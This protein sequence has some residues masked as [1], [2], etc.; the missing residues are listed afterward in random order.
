M[1]NPPIWFLK[2]GGSLITDKQQPGVIRRDTLQRLAQEIAGAVSERQPRTLLL[3]HGSG[4]FGHVVAK[5]HRLDRVSLGT[6]AGRMTEEQLTGVSATQSRAAQLHRL[7]VE[8]LQEAGLRPFSVVP[9]SS[10]TASA[11]LEKRSF[12]RPVLQALA[13]GL[14]PVTHGDVVMDD[15]WGASICSTE[16][17]FRALVQEFGRHDV[18]V[19]RVL[20][21]GD[22]EGVY[23]ALGRTLS[24]I[25]PTGADPPP[26]VGDASGI[27][28]T[29]GMRHRL[30]TALALAE[31]G[32]SSWIFSGLRVGN[33]QRALLGEPVGGTNVEAA[34]PATG[35][36]TAVV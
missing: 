27:D 21:A 8:A 6:N 32:V 10:L 28:V 34:S 15:C 11:G 33:V 19:A 12:V 22:T 9:S 30:Q 20:W 35:S 23:D 26:D 4:S 29:G 31:V 25:G 16:T 3:G 5:E 24:C 2:L 13:A 14:L 36:P 7:V 18:S 1:L 17:V